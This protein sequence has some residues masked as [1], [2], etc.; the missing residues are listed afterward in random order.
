MHRLQ[1]EC[2]DAGVTL[3]RME[4]GFIRS[5]RLGSDSTGPIPLVVDERAFYDPSRPAN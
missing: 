5:V 2:D 1:K 4:D 3:A